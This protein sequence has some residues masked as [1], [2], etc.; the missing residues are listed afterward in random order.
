MSIESTLKLDSAPGHMQSNH[1]TNVTSVAH[2][3][4]RSRDQT[5]QTC[6]R[7]DVAYYYISG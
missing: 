1:I 6:R 7:A 5:D 2:T 4:A 3:I